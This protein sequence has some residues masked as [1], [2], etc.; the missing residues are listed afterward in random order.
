MES[1]LLFIEHLNSFSKHFKFTYEVSS[2]KVSFLDT[3]VKI[4]DNQII[5][6]LFS[7]PTDS[8]NYL[9]YN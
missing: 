7:K 9:V 2:E 3:W 1:L 5:S 8:R 6:D 4:E